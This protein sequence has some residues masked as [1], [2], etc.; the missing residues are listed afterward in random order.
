MFTLAGLE[1]IQVF[2]TIARAASRGGRSFY[3]VAEPYVGTL[4]EGEIVK[5]TAS[6]ERAQKWVVDYS[7]ARARAIKWL[8]DRY[9][10]ARPINASHRGWRRP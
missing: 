2:R 4:R 5:R 9:L 3:R 6:N 7:A 1:A 10:L 8:G